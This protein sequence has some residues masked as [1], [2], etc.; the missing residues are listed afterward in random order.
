LEGDDRFAG[1][2]V[3][4]EESA[5]GLGAAHVVD[6]FAE[7][8]FLRGRGFEGEDLFEGFADFVVGDEGCALALAEASA[9]EFEA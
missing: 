3:S 9:L 2:Y 1:A 6:D 5:H 7:D 4:L 8:S